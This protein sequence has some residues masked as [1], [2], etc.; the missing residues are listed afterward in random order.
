MVPKV[1]QPHA[2]IGQYGGQLRLAFQGPADAS[3][4]IPM[5]NGYEFLMRWKPD[6]INFTLDELEP[7]SPRAS[8]SRTTAR[9]T[10]SSCARG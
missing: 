4:L 7:M 9:P 8:R 1:V 10:S 5:T 3:W 2:E 6:N